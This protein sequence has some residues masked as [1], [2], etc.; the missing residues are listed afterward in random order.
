MI[1]LQKIEK[2]MEI[3]NDVKRSG[4]IFFDTHMH[5]LEIIFDEFRYERN[6]AKKGVYSFG[7]EEY[8]PP[9]LSN[10]SEHVPDESSMKLFNKLAIL[11]LRR[12]YLHIG[13][14]VLEDHM[15]FCG[16]DKGLLLPVAP[17]VG[18]A[19]GLMRRVKNYYGEAERF[20][21]GYSIPN[22]ISDGDIEQDIA[23]AREMYNA[24]VLKIHPNITGIDL[25]SSAGKER[26]EKI[27]S[28]SGALGM[29]VVI[30]GGRSPV[31]PDMQCWE[32][33]YI[34]NLRRIDFSVTQSPVIIAHGA[35]F[36]CSDDECEEKVIP[37]LKELLDKNN[38]LFVNTAGVS[39]RNLELIFRNIDSKRIV[40]GSDALYLTQWEGLA[41]IFHVMENLNMN[42]EENILSIA[43]LTP[44]S[45]LQNAW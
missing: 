8:A 41:K 9:F 17:A 44:G 38:H 15:D 18:N 43:S 30:H 36:G 31:L 12:R 23:N 42:I 7:E 27:L 13:S 39:L 16:I 4:A 45:L 37:A 40:F 2:Y 3:I 21:M 10:V 1:G 14:K 25:R 26:V 11:T 19:D 34:D 20:V 5:P 22:T 24:K 33:A 32:Y 29:P 28:A 35:T 6:K